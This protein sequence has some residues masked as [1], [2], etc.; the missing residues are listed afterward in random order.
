MFEENE[1][2]LLFHDV[3]FTIPPYV[4]SPPLPSTSVPSVN[5]SPVVTN[6]TTVSSTNISNQVPSSSPSSAPVS[7]S[8]PPSSP[9][10]YHPSKPKSKKPKV[11]KPKIIPFN[12]I[13]QNRQVKF[14][15]IMSQIETIHQQKLQNLTEK[16]EMLRRFKFEEQRVKKELQT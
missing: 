13:M 14:N 7:A 3:S 12:Q 1:K 8:P 4:I 16:A 10:P 5:I 11:E 2:T 9:P 6:P 15:L